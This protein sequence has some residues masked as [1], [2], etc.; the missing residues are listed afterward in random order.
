VLRDVAG[1]FVSEVDVD[2]HVSWSNEL[3]LHVIELKT[4][5]PAPGLAGLASRFQQHVQRINRL[6]AP[7]GA[8][9]MPTAMHPWMDPATEMRLWPHEYSPVYEAY[10]RIFQCTGHGWSN[11]QSTHI[12][13]PFCGDDEL[14]RLHAAIRL[15]LPLMPALAAS[16][17]V[18]ACKSHGALDS[19]LIVYRG[20]AASIPSITGSV[21]PEPVFT[22]I[23][24]EREI[25]H[26]MYRD[27]AAHDPQGILQH[28]W[29][30]SRGA[31]VR[32]DRGAIE[33]RVLD[34][35]E[36]PQADVAIATAIV[37]VLRALV[38]ERWANL[39]RQMAWPVAPLDA[40]FSGT[41]RDGDAYLIDDRAYLEVLGLPGAKP[42]R[43]GEV[44]AHLV[45]SLVDGQFRAPLDLILSEGVL[46][47]RILRALGGELSR[48]RLAE[49]YGELSDALEAG[50]LFTP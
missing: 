40:I 43:A 47:R 23:A 39:Q 20:N 15:V 21:I 28:D 35:Q 41:T 25:L 8:R 3:V 24:Y 13:L 29:L 9:L 38:Q 42:A 16:S 18:Y 19:R 33:I 27:I 7:R 34:I 46:A 44:W 32:F 5:G 45:E 17:P 31:I 2:E 36:S 12:N 14:G 22:R 4:N 30:N 11:L 48:R 37:A 50:R 26:R 10:N 6:L 49:V 1:E